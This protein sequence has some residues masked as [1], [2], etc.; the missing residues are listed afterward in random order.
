MNEDALSIAES[1]QYNLKNLVRLADNL[2]YSTIYMVICG[3]VDTLVGLLE[4]EYE[5]DGAL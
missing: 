3:Q 2:S 5:E 1:I 4:D